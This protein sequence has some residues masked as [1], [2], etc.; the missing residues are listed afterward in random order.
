[1]V[2]AKW[3]FI[4]FIGYILYSSKASQTNNGPRSEPPTPMLTTS[5]IGLPL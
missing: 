4:G 5:E 1:M 2:E 3:T